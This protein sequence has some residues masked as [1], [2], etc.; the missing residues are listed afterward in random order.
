MIISEYNRNCKILITALLAFQP[1]IP[2]TTFPLERI[3]R[4]N[5]KN[6]TCILFNKENNFSAFYFE[7][8]SKCIDLIMYK[9]YK[10]R[11]FFKV[12]K[13]LCTINISEVQAFT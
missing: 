2:A 5:N 8:E 1:I 9:E 6:F 4:E 11:Y 7:T 3:F 12:S 13:L 10:T